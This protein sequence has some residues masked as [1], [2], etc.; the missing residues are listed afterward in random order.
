MHAGRGICLLHALPAATHAQAKASIDVPIMQVPAALQFD[1]FT[2]LTISAWVRV[3]VERGGTIAGRTWGEDQFYFGIGLPRSWDRSTFQFQ[4]CFEC[5]PADGPCVWPGDAKC[6]MVTGER[7]R[8]VFS[9][10][11]PRPGLIRNKNKGAQSS[12]SQQTPMLAAPPDR[13]S[14]RRQS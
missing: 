3:G 6:F 11:L 9:P 5:A 14:C 2:S 7:H 4:A 12:C 1:G 8:L 10:S 13:S